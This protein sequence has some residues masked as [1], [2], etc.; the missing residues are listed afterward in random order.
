MCERFTMSVRS[1]TLALNTR[2]YASRTW[3]AHA[4][5]ARAPG[6]LRALLPEGAGD[7]F[8]DVHDHPGL[9]EHRAESGLVRELAVVPV[10]RGQGPVPISL[11]QQDPAVRCLDHTAERL[12]G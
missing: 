1:W 4:P 2:W 12:D 6:A 11:H 10:R 7:A 3:W 5:V 8:D 9:V